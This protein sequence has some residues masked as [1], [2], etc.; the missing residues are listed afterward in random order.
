M[1]PSELLVLGAGGHSKVVI[2]VARALDVEVVAVFDDR[3]QLHGNDVL[4]CPVRGPIE[5]AVKTKVDHAVIAIGSNAARRDV[6]SQIDLEWATLVHPAAM[7]DPEAVIGNG[8]VVFAGGIVQPG[9]HIG[10]HVIINTGASVDHD[11]VVGDYVHV[12]PGVR[13]AGNVHI[14]NGALIGIGA[15][16]TPGMRIGEW[17]TV[18]AGAAVVTPVRD[19]STVVGVPARLLSR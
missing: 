5:M 8:T 17:A 18:G 10:R 14:G 2:S 3:E 1:T 12:A 11:T 16:V 6:A 13:L 15:S 9:A 4:G 19:R 7:V